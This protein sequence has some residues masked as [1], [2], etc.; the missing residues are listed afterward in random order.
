MVKQP[1]SDFRETLYTIDKKGNRR[2]VYSSLTAGKWFTR[3]AVVA[4]TL[5]ALYLLAPWI[6]VAGEQAVHFDL[7]RRRLV[8][9]GEVFWATDTQFLVLIL[10][11]LGLSLFFFTALFGRVWC[12]WACPE[13]VFLEFVFRP[14]E[15][16]I[17]GSPTQRLK[18]DTAPW[19]F[20]KLRIKGVK[21]VVFLIL[22]WVLASTALAYFLGRESLLAMM[23]G[24]PAAH[25]TPFVLTLLLMGVMVFQFGW[26]REQFCTILC[27]YARFQSVLLDRNSLSVWYDRRRGEPRGKARRQAED[28]DAQGDCI[29]CGLC[30]RVC[31]TGIDI[32]NGLQLECIACAACVDACNSIMDSVGKPRGLIR[33]E[34]EA[35]LLDGAGK[36]LRPRVFLYGAILCVVLITFV[37]LLRTRSLVEAFIT[38][39]AGDVPYS[40]FDETTIM[41]HLN[42]KISN[43]GATEEKVW[44]EIV[45]ASD[46]RLVVPV[47]PFPVAGNT[48]QTVPLFFHTPLSTL[49]R[50][51][52]RITVRFR[53]EGGYQ[54]DQHVVLLGPDN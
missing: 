18:L 29:D 46:V 36:I 53:T 49:E 35:R 47:N 31:P 7:A 45:D 26:F 30:V 34:T 54:Q 25:L 5:M 51:K 32:R 9:L 27:P 2:W 50:G 20:R 6:T 40:R 14:I 43:K 19:N 23:A 48:L 52:R 28:P 39:G 44:V 11:S 41:N 15:R 38:R 4:Y 10:A 1:P 8:V 42:A 21:Y 13:T 16:L 33:Y 17:E 12:G 3:R 37:T 22:S 24:S